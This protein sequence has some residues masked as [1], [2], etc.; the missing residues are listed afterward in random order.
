MKNVDTG[1]E[2]TFNSEQDIFDLLNMS[3]VWPQDRN[4]DE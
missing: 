3:Y 1:K 2:I 4:N